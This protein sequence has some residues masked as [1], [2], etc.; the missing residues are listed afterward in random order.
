MRFS[1]LYLIFLLVSTVYGQQK[2]ILS[3]GSVKGVIRDSVHNYAVRS[4]TAAIYKA[5]DH[6]LLSYQITNNNGEFNFKNI[7]VGTSLK[8]EISF[9]GYSGAYR[10]FTISDSTNFIDLKTIKLSPAEISLKEVVVSIPPVSMKGDTLEFHANAFKLD[11]NAVV[12]DLLRKIPNITLWGDGSITVNGREVK[13]LMVNGKQFFGTDGKIATQNIPKNAVDK[14]QVYNVQRNGSSTAD[15]LLELNIKLKKNKDRGYFG[16]IGT[17]YGSDKKYES[18]AILNSFTSKLQLSAAGATNN[19][20]KSAN[21]IGTLLSN[22]SFKGTGTNIVYQPDFESSD[23]IESRAV[24]LSGEYDFYGKAVPSQMKKIN[25]DYFLQKKDIENFS[26]LTRANTLSAYNLSSEKNSSSSDINRTDHHLTSRFSYMKGTRSLTLTQSLKSSRNNGEYSN[27]I[28]TANDQDKETSFS[29]ANG[30]QRSTDNSFDFSA[31][32]RN[33]LKRNDHALFS[34]LYS[35]DVAD[36][37]NETLNISS[38]VSFVDPLA[39]QNF[40]RAYSKEAGGADQQVVMELKDIYNKWSG[41][42][43]SLG[44][45]L[46]FKNRHE[47][48]LVQ[49]YI[50][51]DYIR[52]TYLSNRVKTRTIEEKPSLMVSKSINK[53]LSNRFLKVFSISSTIRQ[54]V[55]VQNIAS[56]KA[57]QNFK[58]TYSR[59]APEVNLEYSN[60]Q[61]G[62][63]DRTVYLKYSTDMTVPSLD[64]LAPLVDSTNFYYRRLGNANLK[65]SITRNLSVR[66]INV[67]RGVKNAFDYN[68]GIN[69]GM[70][71]DKRSD[72]TFINAD[73]RRTVMMINLDGSK[74]LNFNGE[75]RKSFKLTE[76]EI[77]LKMAALLNFAR[78]PSYL[79]NTYLISEERNISADLGINYTLK[80]RLAIE[81][82]LTYYQY[83]SKQKAFNLIYTGENVASVFSSSYNLTKKITVSSNVTFKQS[84]FD[85]NR[86]INFCIWNANA[87]YRFL[88][89]HNGE[90]KFSALDLLRQNS[91]VVNYGSENSFTFGTQSALKQY[92]MIM[93]SYYPRKFGKR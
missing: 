52:N 56:E 59:F 43:F 37:E 25:V 39:N 86:N 46:L 73:N 15:S 60:K 62:L 19:I 51:N 20:N 5:D 82:K 79:N 77:Q 34:A 61:F 17:G 50:N 66:F 6:S 87:V 32:Y 22:S 70:I 80:D 9:V 8:V 63:F 16:K 92:F 74:F 81:S 13:S 12:E 28:H 71:A 90:V 85:D 30:N 18:D 38:F 33:S 2:K 55:V 48:N 65:E 83:N 47:D 58:N 54:I 91:N 35:V 89:G 24:G 67:K 78:N 7:P 88:K 75:V 49:D 21:N 40:N 29:T 31:Y 53:S 27:S 10:V 36:Q 23:L 76:S 45:N 44:N 4:A 93:L 68:L 14:I 84:R 42:S 11:S 64:Q 72:S 3:P 26:D 1:S 69:V 57:F 41:L